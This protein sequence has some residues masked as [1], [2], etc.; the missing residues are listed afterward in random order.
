MSNIETIIQEFKEKSNGKYINDYLPDRDFITVYEKKLN[1]PF[2][3]DYKK[4]LIEAMN[5]YLGDL[6]LF[7]LSEKSNHVYELYTH[8]HEA[9][10][11]GV[12]KDRLAFAS[13]NG[14]YFCFDKG[15]KVHYWSHDGLV[16]ENWPDFK[17]WVK[18]VWIDGN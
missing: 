4:F 5:Y 18:D 12:P 1:F 8:A 6:M 13:D 15:G 3:S 10:K 17:T 2:P 9:W 16:D 14:N 11:I 7:Q